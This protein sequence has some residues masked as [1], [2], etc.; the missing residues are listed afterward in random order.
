MS[1]TKKFILLVLVGVVLI[2]ISVPF[3]IYF[4]SFIIYN[5]VLLIFTIVDYFITPTK[6]AFEVERIG[7]DKLSL[8]EE[9]IIMIRIYNKSKLPA[10]IEVLHEF[11]NAFTCK[12]DSIE[13]R[14]NPH[15]SEVFTFKVIPNKRGA[16]L[17]EEIYI[18]R[19]GRLGLVKKDLLIKNS[20]E[21]KV[22]PSLK[23][24]KKYH[25]MMRKDYFINNGE[26]IIKRKS[27]GREFE[28]LREYVRGD[29]I[30]KINWIKTAR[31]NKL[32]VNQYEPEN[33]KHIYI[34][35]DTGRTMSYRIK[36]YSKLDLAINAAVFLSDVVCYNKDQ[37][38]LM[39]F[40]TKVDTFIKP[41]KGDY[42]RNN[43][44]EALYHVEGTRLTSN[45]DEVL[46]YLSS[47]EKRRSLICIFTDMDT[48]QEV[49]YI[50]KGLEYI[51]KKHQVLMFLVKDEKLDE[52][53]NI[54]VN[55]QK[56]AFLKGIGYKMKN[57]RKKIIKALSRKGVICIE[58]DK[59]DIIY[60]A[61]NEYMRIK[62]REAI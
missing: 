49:Y 37:S 34:L 7:E 31:E 9:E 27:D 10:T 16:F 60:K 18:R 5:T 47:K 11:P 56:D 53:I 26:K 13:G 8:F 14:I 24:L 6:N 57:E 30:R 41:S 28:S 55:N 59:E 15:L 36:E 20:K 12:N 44:L 33:N 45:Y 50:E 19:L 3:G 23:N 2:C 39:I 42:H 61:V 54:E 48:L 22:Y 4:E 58:C 46:F 1:I 51:T 25:M 21:Y 43:I 35:L 38:G 62:N 17:F 29:D 32:M 40:N 52:A